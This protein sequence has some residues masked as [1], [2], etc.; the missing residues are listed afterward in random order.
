MVVEVKHRPNTA[1]GAQDIRTFLVDGTIRIRGSTSV[2][3]GQER[4]VN[5]AKGGFHFAAAAQLPRLLYEFQRACLARFT[6]SYDMSG[7]ELVT[8][9]SVTH[10]ELVLMHPFREGNGRIARLLSDV[11]AVQAGHDILNYS[12]W[13]EN[14]EEYYAAIQ[15][16]LAKNYEPMEALFKAV[17]KNQPG[18]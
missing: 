17:I 9:L 11:M 4:S 5:L 7:D 12:R 6:P 13:N 16:G 14:R 8:A 2:G 15:H 1:M 18:E 10:V 3:A